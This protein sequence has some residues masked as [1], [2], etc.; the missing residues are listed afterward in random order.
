[1]QSRIVC[2]VLGRVKHIG[3]WADTIIWSRTATCFSRLVHNQEQ[4]LVELRASKQAQTPD[5][6]RAASRFLTKTLYMKAKSCERKLFYSAHPERYSS[7]LEGDAL[8]K[9]QAELGMR[10]EDLVRLQFPNGHLIAARDART[11]LLE[12]TNW[13][14]ENGAAEEWVL[15]QPAFKFG[16]SFARLDVLIKRGGVVHVIEVKSRGW[17]LGDNLH[18]KQNQRKLQGGAPPKLKAKWLPF[19]TEL[20]FQLYVL[21]GS[22]PEWSLDVLRLSLQLINKK[23]QVAVNGLCEKLCRGQLLNEWPEACKDLLCLVDV[24]ADA[25]RILR[26]KDFLQE[27][28]RFETA[29]AEDEPLPGRLDSRCRGCEFR[30]QTT[31]GRPSSDGFTECWASRLP[32]E[33]VPSTNPP[34]VFDVWGLT[35][36]VCNEL[37]RDGR[38]FAAQMRHSDLLRSGEIEEPSQES[39]PVPVRELSPTQRRWEQIRR[40]QKGSVKPFVAAAALHNELKTWQFPLHFV[41]FETHASVLPLHFGLRPFETVLFQFSHHVV[42]ENGAVRHAGEFLCAGPPVDEGKGG[43]AE[44]PSFACLRELKLQLQGDRGTL[45]TYGN[46]ELAVLSRVGAQLRGSLGESVPD[47]QE[48]L[49]FLQEFPLSSP[50]GGSDMDEDENIEENLS[51]EVQEG[52][53]GR[54]AVDMLKVLLRFYYSPLTGGSNALKT[55]LPAVLNESLYLQGKYSKPIYGAQQGQGRQQRTAEQGPLV[56]SRNFRDFTWVRWDQNGELIS[57]YALLAEDFSQRGKV[58]VADGGAALAAYSRLR[59]KI[60]DQD[61]Q[62]LARSL[63]RYC[64]LDTFAM[65]LLYEYWAQLCREV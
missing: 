20:S 53:K 64:E 5:T 12:T 57:P 15:F 6:M 27:V 33:I 65:V 35:A 18:I 22:R 19:V 41:D 54:H 1:M 11:A 24:T 42:E 56:F 50:D 2:K 55:V 60:H 16:R 58:Q 47:R 48:L 43:Q 62:E 21:T 39:Q 31:C 28:A 45:L 49:E 34:F 25:V 51:V 46:H 30:L 37:L 26:S 3:R 14:A 23:A 38:P 29:L 9:G 4:D 61:R 52:G 36:K 7:T 59:S 32:K 8:L 10:V 44:L 40:L 17:T 13:L 63:L